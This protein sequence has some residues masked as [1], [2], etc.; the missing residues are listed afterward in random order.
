MDEFLTE[1]SEKVFYF[2]KC[3][4][5]KHKFKMVSYCDWCLFYKDMMIFSTDFN[6]I[7]NYSSIFKIVDAL[8]YWCILNKQVFDD[9]YLL[10]TFNHVFL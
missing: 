6:K 7:R 10:P 1:T 9:F 4:N 2:F 3:P 8:N 5:W